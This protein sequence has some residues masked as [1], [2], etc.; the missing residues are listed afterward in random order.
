MGDEVIRD[1][2]RSDIQ[3]SFAQSLKEVLESIH[4]MQTA[5][6]AECPPPDQHTH[7]HSLVSVSLSHSLTYNTVHE[8]LVASVR[9]CVCVCVCVCERERE[10][11]KEIPP[12]T[13]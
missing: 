11:E 2:S 10:R 5:L 4:T 12:T 7:H 1:P 9:K 6:T 13:S 3:D 8:R